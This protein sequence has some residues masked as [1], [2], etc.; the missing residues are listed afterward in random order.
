[1]RLRLLSSKAGVRIGTRE[2]RDVSAYRWV[3]GSAAVGWIGVPDA[4]TGAGGKW[5]LS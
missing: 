1:M 2:Y 3:G 4:W 5:Y